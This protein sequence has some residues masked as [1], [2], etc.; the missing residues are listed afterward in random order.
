MI[1]YNILQEQIAEGNILY[2]LIDTSCNIVVAYTQT[3]HV[4]QKPMLF[5]AKILA[6][7]MKEDVNP[8]NE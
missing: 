3:L 2:R 5:L 8:C 1:K 7:K 6:T 4:T